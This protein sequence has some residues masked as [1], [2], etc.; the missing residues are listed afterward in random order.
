MFHA[1]G[2]TTLISINIYIMVYKYIENMAMPNLE[3]FIKAVCFI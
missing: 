1:F 2:V 3:N